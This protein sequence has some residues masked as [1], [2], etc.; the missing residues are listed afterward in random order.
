MKIYKNPFVSQPCYFVKTG[1]G[2]SARG[3]AITAV[4]E[5]IEEEK[6]YDEQK[7]D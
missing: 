7:P 3:E 4:L 5:M 2:W 6:P 1:A